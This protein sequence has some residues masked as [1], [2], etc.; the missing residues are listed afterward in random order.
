MSKTVTIH[1]VT[2][3]SHNWGRFDNYELSHGRRD[4]GVQR[5]TRE[6][7]D[8]GSSAA[9]L[10]YAAETGT[11]ILTRQFRLPAHLNGD[12]A[13]MIEVPAG[14]LDGEAPEIAARRE[15]LEETGYSPQD[16]VLV[17]N[18]YSSPGSLTEKCACFIGRYVPGEKTEDGG[19][20]AEEGEDIEVIEI[21]LDA[22]MAMVESGEIAD[23]KTVLLLQALRLRLL[24]APA[25]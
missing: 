5:V 13:W 2:K 22:A 1:S 25:P 11:V 21:T 20:L 9:V 24:A 10:L 7:Y 23:A 14:M 19:G 6:I 8:H 12:D 4:G 3:L 17:S 15:A 18:A 16:L